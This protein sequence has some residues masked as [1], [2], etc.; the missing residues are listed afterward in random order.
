MRS[1]D[2]LLNEE[3]TQLH[4][5]VDEYRNANEATLDA[6]TEEQACRRLH[7]DC[8]PGGLRTL[9]WVYWQVLREFAHHCGH[10]DI[11]R[12]QVRAG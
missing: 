8:S 6:L 3:R 4:A 12:D 11:L 9:R 10:A 1:F 7:H 2:V 5:F